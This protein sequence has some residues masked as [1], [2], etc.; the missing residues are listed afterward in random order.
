MNSTSS[1]KTNFPA[2]PLGDTTPHAH[3]NAGCADSLHGDR[4]KARATP[5]NR[6]SARRPVAYLIQD[7]FPRRSA[8]KHG[9]RSILVSRARSRAMG[10]PS[11]RLSFPSTAPTI[12]YK[13]AGLPRPPRKIPFGSWRFHRPG[14]YLLQRLRCRRMLGEPYRSNYAI[15][16]LFAVHSCRP[17]VL[18]A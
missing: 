14:G 8:G 17:R 7:L 10:R 3:R 13:T 4:M 11:S 1:H 15:P 18:S 16:L 2:I 9:S 12:Q 5:K 6:G